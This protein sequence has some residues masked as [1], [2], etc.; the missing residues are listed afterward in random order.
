[1]SK[2]D[3][4]GFLIF[5]LVFVSGDIEVGTNVSCE[6]STVS[7]CTGLILYVVC[8]LDHR[9]RVFGDLLLYHYVKFGCNRCSNFNNMQSLIF[10]K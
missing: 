7:P 10:C 4:A 1:M 5:G 3:W 6:E 2:F 8:R 9:R